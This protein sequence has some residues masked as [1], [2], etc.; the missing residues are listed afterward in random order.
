M[1]DIQCVNPS[2]LYKMGLGS[3]ELYV[4]GGLSQDWAKV[5]FF[6]KIVY[7]PRLKM[8]TLTFQI[9]VFAWLCNRHGTVEHKL[10][11]LTFLPV[12]CVATRGSKHIPL[13]L[14]PLN[15]P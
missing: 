13:A 14:D 2:R 11:I 15:Y 6:S 1:F 12:L 10:N 3:V 9:Y 4:A 7:Y 8:R 5:I